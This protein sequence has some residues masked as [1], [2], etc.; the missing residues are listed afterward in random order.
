MLTVY[1]FYHKIQTFPFLLCAIVLQL[2]TKVAF[3][4]PFQLCHASLSLLVD[5]K[6]QPMESLLVIMKSVEGKNS[7][8]LVEVEREMLTILLNIC[9]YR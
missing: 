9:D 1:F 6:M 7:K 5:G 3:S 2:K 4:T 8:N